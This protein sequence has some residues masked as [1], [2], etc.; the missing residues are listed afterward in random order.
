[1]SELE[2]AVTTP[3]TGPAEPGELDTIAQEL[4]GRFGVPVS[5]IESDTVSGTVSR[6]IVRTAIFSVVVA[7]LFILAYIWWAFRA[8][9]KPVRYGVSAIIALLHDVVVVI[10]VFSIAGELWNFEVNTMFITA[11]LTVIGF[12]VHDTIVVFDR[13]RENLR[14][15]ISPSFDVTVNESLLQTLARSITT[16]L[17]VIFTLLALLLLGGS[18]IRPFVLVLLLGIVSGTYSSIAIASQLLVVWEHWSRRRR[19]GRLTPAATAG[20]AGD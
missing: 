12:S 16:S 19:L 14:R 6:E 9:Q 20:A 13:I 4:S 1:M 18:T 15:G 17:T 7:T 11:L 10:G 8:V 2:G 3:A 5:I